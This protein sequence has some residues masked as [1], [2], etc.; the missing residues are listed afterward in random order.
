MKLDISNILFLFYLLG[1]MGYFFFQLRKLIRNVRLGRPVNRTNRKAE[2]WKLLFRIALG[3]GKMIRRPV[4]GILHILVY[5]GFLI[6]NVELLEILIDDLF[7]THRV[8][9][10]ALGLA[11]YRIFTAILE[12]FA[13]LVIIAVTVFFIRRNFRHINCFEKP[14]MKTWPKT[15]ANGIL[16][17]EFLLMTAFLTMNAADGLLHVRGVGDSGE[18]AGGFLISD[19]FV[20]VYL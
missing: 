16:I 4:V 19:L 12:V 10:R 14:E 2:R 17:F 15:D 18:V 1:G 8:L 6:V 20:R 3:Q 5:I 11:Y 7:G 9:I 13:F